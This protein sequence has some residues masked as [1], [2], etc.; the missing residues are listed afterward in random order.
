MIG[1]LRYEEIEQLIA[2]LSNSTN[3]VRQVLNS[4]QNNEEIAPRTEKMLHFCSDIEK[5]IQQLNNTIKLNKDSDIVIER[6]RQENI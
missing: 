1:K 3:N 6:I 2:V 5:Y 4:Y